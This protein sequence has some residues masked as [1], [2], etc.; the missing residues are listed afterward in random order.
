MVNG[1][2]LSFYHF[3]FSFTKMPL[4]MNIGRKQYQYFMLN[5][6]FYTFY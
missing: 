1:E 3:C 4:G 6:I 5:G 2:S